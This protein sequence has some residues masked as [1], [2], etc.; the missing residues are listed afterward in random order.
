MIVPAPPWIT[1]VTLVIIIYPVR[2]ISMKNTELTCIFRGSV[3]PNI[4]SQS[5]LVKKKVHK[6]VI[7]NRSN[8]SLPAHPR[9][10]EIP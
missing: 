7:P 3:F 5:E 10:P 8:L 2:Q 4:G 1:F 9:Q 6:L